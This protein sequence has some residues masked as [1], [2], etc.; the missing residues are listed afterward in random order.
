MCGPTSKTIQKQAEAYTTTTSNKAKPK[1]ESEYKYWPLHP[2]AVLALFRLLPTYLYLNRG[3]TQ[4]FHW[5]AVA[6]LLTGSA[7][8]RRF[9]VVQ[10]TGISLGWYSAIANDWYWNGK[11][12]HV[13]YKN[14]PITMTNVMVDAQT[15]VLLQSWQSLTVMGVS[16]LLD[17]LAHPLL[18]LLFWKLH[19]QTGGSL[20]DIF[21]WKVVV[22]TYMLSRL[23]SLTHTL[24]NYGTAGWGLFYFGHNVYIM[25]DLESW[26]AAYS[27]EGVFYASIVLYK[28][29]WEEPPT[30]TATTSKATGLVQVVTMD[31]KPSLTPSESGVSM[32][33]M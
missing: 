2:V 11:F 23:W 21:A 24:H 20:R 14:M 32:E 31:T 25:D 4:W 19:C 30:T 7:F 15:R 16:H 1:A 12:C 18:T 27:A 8:L 33:S 26:I 9:L 13:L 22:S 29:F 28:I 17:T 5:T 3:Y 6:Y 10:G